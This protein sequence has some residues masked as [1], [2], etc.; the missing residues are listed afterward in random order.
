MSDH[1]TQ[2]ARRRA[3]ARRLPPLPCGRRDPLIPD[4]YADVDLIDPSGLW[5]APPHGRYDPPPQPPS[6]LD[7][8]RTA[9]AL[10]LDDDERKCIAAAGRSIQNHRRKGAG[11]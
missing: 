1:T 5:Q 10:A 2:L 8:L 4:R 6:A 11:A 7:H 3:A 9:H